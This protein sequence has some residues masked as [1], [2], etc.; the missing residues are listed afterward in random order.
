LKQIL[1][2]LLPVLCVSVVVL[3]PARAQDQ[4]VR[5]YFGKPLSFWLEGL[6]S[7]DLLERDEALQVIGQVGPA[8]KDAVPLLKPILK[9]PALATR[10]KAALALWA[11]Q[12]DGADAIPTLAEDFPKMSTGQKQQVFAYAANVKKPDQPLFDLFAVLLDDPVYRAQVPTT[13]TKLGPDAVPFYVK[14]IDARKGKDRAQMI[15]AMPLAFLY[16]SQGDV[17]A[18]YLKDPDPIC[19]A[20][21]AAMLLQASLK[22]DEVVPL[23]VEQAQ[24]K[25]KEVADVALWN[26]ANYRP[27]LEKAGPAYLAALKHENIQYRLAV[28]QP[29]LQTHPEK[30]DDVLRILEEGLKHDAINIRYRTYTLITEL[31]PKGDKLVPTLMKMLREAKTLQD[32]API[33][34]ALGPHA[35]RVAGE[36]GE[37]LFEDPKGVSGARLLV[38]QLRA[39]APHLVE[40]VTKALEGD[41]LPRKQL[42]VKAAR[43]FPASEG[44]KLVASLAPLLRNEELAGPTL[45]A[46]EV[47]GRESRPAAAPV[48]AVYDRPNGAKWLPAV[49]RVLLR[50]EPEPPALDAMLK[51]LKDRDQP[52]GEERLFAAELA[53][54]HPERRK[55]AVAWLE[56]IVTRKVRGDLFRAWA[57]LEKVGPDAAPLV[58][59]LAAQLKANPRDVE[60]MYKVLIRI[61]PPAREVVPTLLE[62]MK[63]LNSTP[64]AIRAGMVIYALD[65]EKRAAADEQI[66]QV[67]GEHLDRY[68]WGS[69]VGFFYGELLKLCQMKPGPTKALVPLL[70]RSFRSHTNDEI[71][72][73]LVPYLL[74]LDK[75]YEE[76][77]VKTYEANLGYFPAASWAAMVGLLR[78]Q[79]DHPRALAEVKKYLESP[80]FYHPSAGAG[81]AMQCERELPGVRELLAAR[82]KTSTEFHFR[83]RAYI[84]LMRYEG[85]L[86]P[87]WVDEILEQAEPRSFDLIALRTLGR[88]GKPL[89]PRLQAINTDEYRKDRIQAVI[90]ALEQA[91]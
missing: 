12:G 69:E 32:A 54:L 77:V 29:V 59:E 9:D 33:L 47:F 81:V 84:T 18:K 53:L 15:G 10:L 28:V 65:P 56:P 62:Q 68:A 8:G 2:V 86:N 4:G 17:L 43:W 91:E 1:T 11:V 89:I 87:A 66:A 36:I 44:G 57:I 64:V 27:V 24:S 21:A 46:L 76:E 49:R 41:D 52:T 38:P 88:V 20:Y 48:F 42:A 34:G 16:P 70:A 35:P 3:P 80:T 51:K 39:F 79:P 63:T 26:L 40:P 61:G 19:Q 60:N 85:K 58:P 90:D 67:F 55:E 45:E 78:I 31:G 6:K 23:L 7:K 83:A 14:L 50:M 37:M 30:A 72:V 25:E 22:T 5:D 13:L 75:T 73:D 74:R 82:L 71:G